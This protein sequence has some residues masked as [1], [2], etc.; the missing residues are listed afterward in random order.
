MADRLTNKQI[1]KICREHG[2]AILKLDAEI[3]VAPDNL[4]GKAAKMLSLLDAL[5]DGDF[6]EEDLDFILVL[7]ASLHRRHPAALLARLHSRSDLT[8]D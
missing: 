1:R 4:E 7:V 3:L 5:E 6:S 8:H 2:G